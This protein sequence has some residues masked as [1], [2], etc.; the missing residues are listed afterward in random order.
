MQEYFSL[1]ISHNHYK[2]IGS[3]NISNEKDVEWD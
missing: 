1:K 2:R 3:T